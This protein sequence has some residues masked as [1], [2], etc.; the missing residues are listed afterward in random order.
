MH[1]LRIRRKDASAGLGAFQSEARDKPTG[2]RR[3]ALHPGTKAGCPRLRA[4]WSAYAVDASIVLALLSV[5]CAGHRLLPGDFAAGAPRG[6]GAAATI[7]TYV[8]AKA[9]RADRYR[10]L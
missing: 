6:A 4:F 1:I 5:G 8:G 7:V 3:R 10:G 9:Q 2:Q